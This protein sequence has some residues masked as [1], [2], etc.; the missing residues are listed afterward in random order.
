MLKKLLRDGTITENHKGSGLGKY[1]TKVRRIAALS[2]YTNSWLNLESPIPLQGGV[3][4]PVKTAMRHSGNIV[5]PSLDICPPEAP[6]EDAREDWQDKITEYFE[7][8]GMVCMS[9]E[10]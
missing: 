1:C 4:V 8:I 6:D 10:R 7:W 3:E 9:S 5:V 2:I